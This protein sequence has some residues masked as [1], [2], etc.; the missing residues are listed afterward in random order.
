MNL[1][2]EDISK[3]DSVAEQFLKEI[4][5]AKVI[6]FYAGMGVG[7]TTFIKSLCE[8]LS[9]VDTVTSPTFAIINEYY[10]QS[11]EVVYHF[12]FY[13]IKMIKEVVDLGIDDYFFSGN[14]CFIEWPEKVEQVLP[15]HTLRV[16][17]T[18]SPN[19][20]RIISLKDF[21]N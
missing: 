8:K 21:S 12:D 6:A 10:T 3:I 13:R 4:G 7:K 17:I 1:L 20:N 16:E 19:G 9:V 11:N 5:E 18:E 14:F 15:E 2:I